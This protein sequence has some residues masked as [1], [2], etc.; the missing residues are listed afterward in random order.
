MTRKDGSESYNEDGRNELAQRDL[1]LEEEV[2]MT[3]KFEKYDVHGDPITH[4]KRYCN[5]LR[6]VEEKDELLMAYFGESLVG[7]AS[8]WFID[9]DVSNR[10]TWYDLTRCFVQQFQYTIDI[11]PDR[12]SLANMKKKTTEI[13]REYAIRWREKAARVKPSMKESKMI[14]VFLQAQEPDYFHYLLSVVGKTF[15]KV[16]KIE[17]MVENGIKSGNIVSQAVLK[18]TIQVIKNG[19]ESLGGMK[20]KKDV[21]IV[22]SGTQKSP[23]GS[24]YQYAPS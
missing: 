12:S 17:E 1:E 3:P 13:F 24:L 9:Q 19:S 21:A 5:Q 14:D 2:R 11:V 18:A 20:L 16:I 7:I 22:M 4:L 8:E 23:R 10:H 6:G 15:T